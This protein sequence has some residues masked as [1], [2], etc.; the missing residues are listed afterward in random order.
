MEYTQALADSL[1][2]TD[3]VISGRKKDG[4]QY[5]NRRLENI[6]FKNKKTG[7]HVE[8]WCP[9]AKAVRGFEVALIERMDVAPGAEVKVAL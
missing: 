2:G 9:V 4:T 3:V 7:W 1:K 5:R 8:G 6:T